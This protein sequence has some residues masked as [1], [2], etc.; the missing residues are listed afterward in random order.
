MSNQAQEGYHV[1]AIGL[2]ICF[3]MTIALFSF[4]IYYPSLPDIAT[5]F[6]VSDSCIQ[7][8][9]PLYFFPLAF[10]QLFFGPLS[11]AYGRKKMLLTGTFFALAGSIVCALSSTA[12]AFMA[13]RFLQGAGVGSYYTLTRAIMRDIFEGVKLARFNSL[14]SA[15][16]SLSPCFAPILGSYCHTYFGWRSNFFLLSLLFGLS[17][18]IVSLF[19]PE[20]RKIA[21]KSQSLFADYVH[22]LKNR[23]YV[24][25][26]LCS[27]LAYSGLVIFLTLA[28]F[29]FECELSLTPIEFSYVSLC[30]M[31]GLTLGALINS[32]LVMSYSLN[33]LITA[34]AILM[35]LSGASLTIL[36]STIARAPFTIAIPAIL[37]SIACNIIFANAAAGALTP[38]DTQ[39]IGTGSALFGCIQIVGP[40]LSSALITALPFDYVH[41][42]EGSFLL[43]GGTIA[44]L[45]YASRRSTANHVSPSV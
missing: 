39:A 42:L 25:Y 31:V 20:T 21:P 43:I 45:V 15:V 28:P 27:T 4:D 3:L 17:S 2:C 18:L 1:T 8:S 13:G 34:G 6:G 24:Q 38:I 5:S 16:L 14:I 41:M 40:A 10:S 12:G 29:I 30:V 36:T 35:L 26:L 23:V 44:W 32:R 9:V 33:T 7:L 19:L 37:F 11:N 22:F